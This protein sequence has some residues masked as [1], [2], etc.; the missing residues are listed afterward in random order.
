MTSAE[1]SKVGDPNLQQ[2]LRDELLLV[3]PG[4]EA[5]ALLRFQPLASIVQAGGALSSAQIASVGAP[6]LESLLRS[7]K[8][9]VPAQKTSPNEWKRWWW[10]CIGGM[11]V[12]FGLVFTMRGRW[13]P[14]AAK[15]DIEERDRL[16][17]EELARLH[18]EVEPESVH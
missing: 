5:P 13:S 16:V 15:R 6:D 7:E 14:A 11:V 9:L 2:V 4:T 1:I 8:V 12:F 10:V 17:A 18:K 3:P